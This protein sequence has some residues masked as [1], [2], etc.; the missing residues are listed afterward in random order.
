VADSD[1]EGDND[2][3]GDGAAK[4]GGVTEDGDAVEDLASPQVP[5]GTLA[6]R[7]SARLNSKETPEEEQDTGSRVPSSSGTRRSRPGRRGK[8]M[9]PTPM[10]P[11]ATTLKRKERS[12]VE[13]LL[14]A[15]S[16]A[17]RPIDVDALNAVLEKFPVKR[18]LQV[19]DCEK[20]TGNWLISF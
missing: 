3:A 7:R 1:V 10:G 6:M 11:P 19:K 15:G 20:L 2:A 8:S 12:E 18:E 16:R 17:T 9:K 14:S 13:E 4:D 5:S